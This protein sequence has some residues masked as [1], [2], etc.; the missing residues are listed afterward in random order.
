LYTDV[1]EADA[2]LD[3][4]TRTLNEIDRLANE[5]ELLVKKY[6]TKPRNNPRLNIG[7]N[8]REKKA[9]E[10]GADTYVSLH[11]DGATNDPNSKAALYRNP[12]GMIDQDDTLWNRNPRAD[13]ALALRIRI[14]VQAAIAAIEPAESIQAS[15]TAYDVW[16]ANHNPNAERLTSETNESRL[17]GGLGALNDGGNP[18]QGNGNYLARG[19]R[20][21]PCRAALIEMERISNEQADNLFN[22]NTAYNS[23]TGAITLTALAESMRARV[24]VNIAGACIDDLL[25][26]DLADESIVPRRT[27]RTPRLDFEDN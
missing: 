22:G 20:Y 4:G 21:T 8:N 25:I 24:A 9:R 19:I 3:I 27:N 18:G 17:Q 12:F 6:S 13:W 14:A 7:L 5:R 15:E 26:R 1:R 11:F 23:A 16:D 2:V 10:Y